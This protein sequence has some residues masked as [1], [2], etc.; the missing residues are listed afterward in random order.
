[1]LSALSLNEKKTLV[2]LPEASKSIILSGR[3]ILNTKVITADQINTYDVVNADQLVVLEG[4]LNKIDN[5][6]TAK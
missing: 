3:N 6:L 2:V 1:M 5:L 4:A